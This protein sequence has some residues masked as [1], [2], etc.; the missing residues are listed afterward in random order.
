MIL[1]K[2]RK[3]VINSHLGVLIAC[4]FLF[5]SCTKDRAVSQ[6]LEESTIK[7][8][9]SNTVSYQARGV[10]Y[11]AQDLFRGIM[12]MS[13]DVANQI[14]EIMEQVAL[15]KNLNPT[16]ESQE[17]LKKMQ[18]NFIAQ[19]ELQN[20]GYINSFA[21]SIL[22]HDQERIKEELTKAQDVIFIAV[23]KYFNFEITTASSAKEQVLSIFQTKQAEIEGL[24][25]QFQLS[26]ITKQEFENSVMNTLHLDQTQL[27]TLANSVGN[28]PDPNFFGGCVAFLSFVGCNVAV[29]INIA[30]YINIALA[31]A[32]AVAA[33]AWV[34][35]YKWTWNN[36][37]STNNSQLDFDKYIN[38]LA[39]S[40]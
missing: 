9:Q 2:I 38:T 3:F 19:I 14:P 5:F 39:I 32:V 17:T 16:Q 20:P 23:S 29:A 1:F 6:V 4:S 27:K 34:F 12:F 35:T 40:F 13:G 31:A 28:N 10:K 21:E 30:G 18:D 33:A 26:Q 11:S 15:I 22:S 7:A 25:T 36:V 37:T 24:L 8:K